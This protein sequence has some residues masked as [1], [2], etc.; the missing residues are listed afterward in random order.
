MENSAS[1]VEALAR[2]MFEAIARDFPVSCASDEFYYF[3]QLRPSDLDWE[4]WDRF[5][6]QG[7]AELA[8]NLSAWEEALARCAADGSLDADA[9]IDLNLLT[10]FARTLREQVSEVR[11]WQTQPTVPLT[12]VCMGL[13]EAMASDDPDAKHGRATGLPAFLDQTGEN[14]A[15]VPVHFRDLGLEMVEDT[16]NYLLFLKETIPEIGPG[17]NA[18]DRFEHAL[19]GASTRQGF[20]LPPAMVE[21]IIRFHIHCDMDMQ[22]VTR[23][24]DEEIEEMRQ[25][26]EGEAG[27][28]VP[29][30]KG[31]SDPLWRE[32]LDGIPGPEIGEQGVIGLYTR[33][34]RRLAD[35]CRGHG[36]IPKGPGSSCPVRVLPM[37]PYVSAIR[38]APSYSISPG[39]PPSQGIFYIFE[40]QGPDETRRRYHREYRMLAAHETYPGH[41]LLDASRWGLARSCRRPVE[42]P[43]F[44]EGWACFA[45][46]IL[47]RTGYF[48]GS[49]DRFLLAKRRLWRA[50]RGKVDIGLQTGG[51]DMEGAAQCLMETGIGREQAMSSARRY[52]LNPGYQLSYTMGLRRFLDLCDRY[53]GDDIQGFAGRVL[54]QGEIGF[55]DLVGIL[56]GKGT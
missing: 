35:H 55:D 29:D 47:R 56:A 25:V 1:S 38:T 45:E 17:I 46:E 4:V 26:L 43:I 40:D 5:S 22:E 12:L 7:V 34:V 23:T 50:I 13:A 48:S 27:R 28:L 42:R 21:R 30:R 54:V 53:G 49:A 41:H 44:Y 3:P 33:E 9:R 14:L 18:L 11:T 52:P 37:P 2:D 8:G 16:R 6:P 20:L 15:D 39:H 31:R 10:G 32:A 24:L 36:L 51:M 19:K